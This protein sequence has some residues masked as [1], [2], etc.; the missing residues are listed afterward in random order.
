MF[1]IH[2]NHKFKM[3]IKW[4][5]EKEEDKFKTGV[6]NLKHDS[7]DISRSLRR[8]LS[9]DFSF[10]ISNVDIIEMIIF[11]K[12]E[13]IKIY[14]FTRDFSSRDHSR[15]IESIFEVIFGDF[16]STKISSHQKKNLWGFNNMNEWDRYL[17]TSLM[18]IDNSEFASTPPAAEMEEKMKIIK[19]L[20]FPIHDNTI[21]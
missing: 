18:W 1:L 15:W 14:K 8:L 19:F 21:I 11:T 20:A 10:F 13:F 5:A 9:L 4:R 6:V 12:C 16:F 17:L 3:C 2:Q 7:V